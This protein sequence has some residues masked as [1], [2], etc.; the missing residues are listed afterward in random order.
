ML[1][2]FIKIFIDFSKHKG[3]PG[4][5]SELPTLANSFG[6]LGENILIVTNVRNACVCHGPVPVIKKTF[7]LRIYT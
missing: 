3:D 2:K 6:E 1:N 4:I 7:S 5:N